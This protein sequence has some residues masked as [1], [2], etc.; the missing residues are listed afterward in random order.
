M[1][2]VEINGKYYTLATGDDGKPHIQQ[3]YVNRLSTPYRTQ[4]LQVRSDDQSV[5]RYISPAFPLG[6]GWARAKRDSGRGVGGMLDSTCST[7]FGPVTLSKL[8]EVQT[9]ATNADHF[10]KAVIFK[11]DLWGMFEEDWKSQS[12]DVVAR[13]YGSSSDDWTGGGLIVDGQLVNSLS[14]RAFDMVAHKSS[15]F[16]LTNGAGNAGGGVEVAY[17]GSHL[18]YC[19]AKSVDG[20]TWTRADYTGWPNGG[21]IPSAMTLINK[22]D[23]DMGK[24][25]SFG[26]TLIAAIYRTQTSDI[27]V[28]STTDSGANWLL[29][30]VIPSGSGPK[31]LVDWY[32]IAGVRS[33]VLVTAEGV[34]SISIAD[35]TIELL[36]AL[37]GDP[38]TGRWSTVGN[39]GSLYVGLGSGQILRLTI[40]VMGGGAMMEVMHIGPPGDGLVATRRGHVTYMLNAPNEF[41]LVAYGGHEAG[42][43]ASIFM[44]D[45]SVVL[46]DPETGK[47]FMP[48]HHMWQD[49]TGNLDIVAMAY[50]TADDGTS[51]LHWAMEG[52]AA[53]INYHIEEPFGN[54][55]QTTTAQYQATGI[56]R[57]PDDDLGDPQTTATIL[58]VLVDA[59]D[60]TAGTGGSGAAGDDF[61]TYRYGIDGAADTTTSLGDFLS[62][63]IT[64]SFG[65]G[66]GIGARRLAQNLLFTRNTT[67]VEERTPKLHELE[68]Q[69]HHVLL[70]R[71]AW[72]FTIDIRASARDWA[73]SVS[74]NERADELIIT[75]LEGVA[76]SN[77]LL[78]F[79]TGRQAQTRVKVPNGQSPV[80]DLT[81]EDSSADE[82]G[83][84]TGYCTIRVE[85]GI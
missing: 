55:A 2:V 7:A 20:A 43:Y 64:K 28:Y 44:I 60:L 51:R 56:L 74:T 30:V 41:L 76:Q 78:T 54:P 4:G 66:A 75:A 81:V 6:I 73:P 79:T 47:S 77:T 5:N 65:S 23:D 36:Y 61:I 18:R 9:H 11:G 40:G 16:T 37:D 42:T 24:L 17:G 3:S 34:Y 48:W 10:L 63:S 52:T 71:L 29:D 45:T 12:L 53:S 26:N 22:F 67:P 8:H 50:S 49:A 13:K 57:L 58:Q 14:S 85:E 15:L 25:L 68:L 62:G 83:W 32:D 27:A 59:D 70:D 35:D 39:D 84:R 82:P 46:T 33:P 21:Y 38:N 80:W 31:A 69:A 72:E 1:A 19:P